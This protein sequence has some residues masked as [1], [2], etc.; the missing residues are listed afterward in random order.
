MGIKFKCEHCHRTLNVKDH[1][2]GKRGICPK[3]QGKIEIPIASTEDDGDGSPDAAPPDGTASVTVRTAPADASA[4]SAIDAIAEAPQLNWYVAPPG[5][6]TKYGPAP[7]DLMRSWI[8]EGRVSSDSLVW[9]EGWPQWRV[10]AQAFPELTR[11]PAGAVLPTPRPDPSAVPL[12]D[13]ATIESEDIDAFD[14]TIRAPQGVDIGVG[15]LD[16]P[17]QVVASSSSSPDPAPQDAF[18]GALAPFDMEPE[19][20]RAPVRAATSY[21]SSSRLSTNAFLISGLIVTLVA[22]VAVLI[23]LLTRQ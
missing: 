13:T 15:D 3:C 6:M 4:G 14:G 18:A 12:P 20:Q 7:G 10:A 5:S 16:E 8:R 17:P 23:Y 9:R 21:S 11:A 1:L 22:L 19:P 2:V